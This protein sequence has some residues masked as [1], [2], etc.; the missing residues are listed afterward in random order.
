MDF[1]SINLSNCF[2]YPF[3]L[4][5]W[6][7]AE[8]SSVVVPHIRTNS[9][10]FALPCAHFTWCSPSP[11]L[12]D[13]SISV[14]ILH[15]SYHIS[16]CIFPFLGWKPRLQ[17]SPFNWF[18]LGSCFLPLTVL[19]ALLCMFFF[20]LCSFWDKGVDLNSASMMCLCFAPY[21]FAGMQLAVWALAILSTEVVFYRPWELLPKTEFRAHHCR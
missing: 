14:Y 1:S 20:L 3:K 8:N 16:P 4:N 5:V 12:E 11:A 2:L 6:L 10:A 13:L 18:L 17:T 9:S 19:F 15:V 7:L 21:S